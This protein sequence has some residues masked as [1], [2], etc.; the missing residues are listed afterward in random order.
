M[1]LAQ[2]DKEAGGH[3]QRNTDKGHRIRQI[4][5][6]PEPQRR[7]GDDF[8]ILHRRKRRGGRE[9]QRKADADMADGGTQAQPDQQPDLALSRLDGV[10]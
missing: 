4:A 10:Q 6:Y 2:K 9:L 8:Q 7:G 5:K 1:P 3:D